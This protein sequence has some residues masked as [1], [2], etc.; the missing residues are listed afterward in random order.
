MRAWGLRELGPGST[1]KSFANTMAP[2][3]FGDMQI[4]A[5][6]EYRFFVTNSDFPNGQFLY[7]EAGKFA[8][9]KLWTD[10]AIGV[11]TGLRIDLGFFLI[12]VDYAFKAKDPSPALLKNQNKWFAQFREAKGLL[13]KLGTGQ[14]QLGVTYPF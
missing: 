1:V 6:A 9:N 14:I 11:G 12:R 3:R 2:E 7:S 4:E 5:N 13:P 10:L 8:F